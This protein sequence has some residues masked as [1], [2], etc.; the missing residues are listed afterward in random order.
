MHRERGILWPSKVAISDT[1]NES[2]AVEVSKL[3]QKK[4]TKHA[5]Q[6]GRVYIGNET[7]KIYIDR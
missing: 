4:I 6:K 1:D 7:I 3:Q 2:R 5:L